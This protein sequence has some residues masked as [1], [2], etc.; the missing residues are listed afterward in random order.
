MAAFCIDARVDIVKEI[1]DDRHKAY[2]S[3]SEAY[4]RLN[5]ENKGLVNKAAERD[6]QHEAV[7][8]QLN[9]QMAKAKE[10]FAITKGEL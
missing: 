10:E 4:A 7:V 2:Q 1:E 6:K 8:K 9:E 3:L 5:E